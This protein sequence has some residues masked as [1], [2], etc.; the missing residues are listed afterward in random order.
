VDSR[1]LQVG[2]EGHTN[3]FIVRIL[4]DA[5]RL[6]A[7]RGKPKTVI[8]N[9]ERTDLSEDGFIAARLIVV[10]GEKIG[11]P[12]G[13]VGLLCPEFKKQRALKNEN[14]PIFRLANAEEKSLQSVF[15]QKQPKILL[16]LPRQSCKALPD[17]CRE[18]GDILGQLRDSI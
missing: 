7:L 3:P 18:I 9:G 6:D 17:R 4:L 2:Q 15:R 14:P 11:V 16:P 10:A 12:S 5:L 13:P 1:T 8:L